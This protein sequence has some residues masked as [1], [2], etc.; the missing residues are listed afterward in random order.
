[1]DSKEND[2]Y[3]VFVY[4]TLMSG[5]ENHGYLYRSD[6]LGKGL[7]L[8]KYHLT[9]SFIPYVS[10]TEHKNSNYIYGEV[11]EVDDQTLRELD[12]LEGHPRNYTRK[13]IDVRLDNGS[14]EKCW[15]YF[16]NRDVGHTEIE[17]GNYYLYRFS[18][19]RA[20]PLLM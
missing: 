1:M 20:R 7:T 2:M 8:N 6:C 16:N 12:L 9:A 14:V 3:K 18:T 15:I 4:G 17:S 19:E 13:E 10:E 5:F 11:Y